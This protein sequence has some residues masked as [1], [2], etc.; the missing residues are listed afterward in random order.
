[1][2]VHHRRLTARGEL[3]DVRD[4]RLVVA[5]AERR[6]LLV[7]VLVLHSLDLRNARRILLVVRG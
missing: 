5:V 2:G 7:D 6:V 3:L 4:D 1:M